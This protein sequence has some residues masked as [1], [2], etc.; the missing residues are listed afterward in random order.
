MNL[1]NNE[2]KMLDILFAKRNKSYGAYAIRSAY[3]STVFRSLFIVAFTVASSI[4]LATWLKGNHAAAH[5]IGQLPIQDSIRVVPYDAKKD[6]ELASNRQETK[7]ETGGAKKTD[8]VSTNIDN[9]A[10]DSTKQALN[11]DP[12][13]TT[14]STIGDPGPSTPSLTGGG[15]ATT[16]SSG[17]GTSDEASIFVDESPEFEGGH[18]ALLAFVRNHL[19]YPNSA[20][21]EHKQGTVYAKFVVD[22]TGKVSNIFLQNNL[23]YGLDDEAMRVLKMIPKFKSPGKVQG[24]PVKTYYQIPIKFKLG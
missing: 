20:I 21:D 14:T 3:G 15:T 19:V 5:E 9:H 24:K 8:G 22:E 7:H 23:G 1:I 17:G 12:V 10:N 4:G 18:A 11:S 16:A 2:Q 13:V 6:P